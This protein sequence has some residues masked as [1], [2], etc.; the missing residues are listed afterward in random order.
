[1]TTSYTFIPSLVHQSWPLH[2]RIRVSIT[3]AV[4]RLKITEE[5]EWSATCYI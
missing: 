1:M 4:Q 2:R 5:I 3:S